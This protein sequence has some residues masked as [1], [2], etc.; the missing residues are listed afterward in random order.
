MRGGGGGGVVLLFLSFVTFL[1]T[2]A[3]KEAFWCQLLVKLI[4]FLGGEGI[5]KIC[6]SAFK[7]PFLCISALTILKHNFFKD[8][9]QYQ[10]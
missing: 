1:C 8:Y 9:F 4:F 10:I 3:W 2:I 6:R 7:F 5:K